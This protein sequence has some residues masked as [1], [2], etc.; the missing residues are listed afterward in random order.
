MKESG[1]VG[2]L[3]NL[4]GVENS[5]EMVSEIKRLIGNFL[6]LKEKVLVGKGGHD[7]LVR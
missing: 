3:F 4:G 7:R 1:Q 5:T 2:F 6:D